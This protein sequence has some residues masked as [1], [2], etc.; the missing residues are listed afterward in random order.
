MPV[1]P[2]AEMQGVAL[3]NH[4]R[5]AL[6]NLARYLLWG[7]YCVSRHFGCWRWVRKVGV[8]VLIS[9]TGAD[10]WARQTDCLWRPRRPLSRLLGGFPASTPYA[11]PAQ[12]L[13]RLRERGQRE[14]GLSE[15]RY[16]TAVGFF[17]RQAPQPSATGTRANKTRLNYAG[18]SGLTP[19]GVINP[20]LRS[21][22]DWDGSLA[23]PRP[24]QTLRRRLVS[25]TAQRIESAA[26]ARI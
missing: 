9:G 24:R 22:R 26:A 5:V 19:V 8:C 1:D 25:L 12:N 13:E 15:L 3:V 7:K 14:L 17:T 23:A 21:R 6:R 2:F 16:V 20:L 4:D 10:I 18:W 11:R